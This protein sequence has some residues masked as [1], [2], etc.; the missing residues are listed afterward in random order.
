MTDSELFRE[1]Q[2]QCLIIARGTTSKPTIQAL[3]EMA[4]E[5]Q[6]KAELLRRWNKQRALTNRRQP[7]EANLTLKVCSRLP[8]AF[9]QTRRVRAGP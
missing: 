7:N 8:M 9:N 4:A 1:K 5:F 2:R 6:A 3:H